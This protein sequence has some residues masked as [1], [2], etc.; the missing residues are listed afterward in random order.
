MKV[1]DLV[2]VKDVAA[3]GNAFM[4]SIVGQTGIVIEACPGFMVW[5]VVML[6]DSMRAYKLMSQ[7]LEVINESR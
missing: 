4:Q 7:D 3:Y 6:C 5:A 2:R 1:G